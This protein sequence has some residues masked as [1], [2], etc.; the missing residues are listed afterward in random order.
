M[1]GF[2][3]YP[4]EI[5]FRE[6]VGQL[7]E[8]V[9][10]FVAQ[11]SRLIIDHAERSH[12]QSAV[13]KHGSTGVKANSACLNQGIVSGPGIVGSIVNDKHFI[14]EDGELTNRGLAGKIGRA[15]C[16][17]RVDKAEEAGE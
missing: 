14:T 8:R 16:R 15:S 4:T 13:V 2:L 6:A 5:D 10:L 7:P 3:K 11:H 12:G 9:N 17:E 1:I